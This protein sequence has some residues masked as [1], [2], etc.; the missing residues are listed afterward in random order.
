MQSALPMTL[1]E[2]IAALRLLYD[3]YGQN[4][5][6]EACSKQSHMEQCAT[7]A[8]EQGE[9][10]ELQL[11]AFLHDVGHLLAEHRQIEERDALGFYNHSELGAEYL[12]ELGFASEIV[13]LV[14]FHVQAKRY[15]ATVD[16]EY[17]EHLSAASL[18]T[19]KQQGGPMNG[20]ESAAF[21]Q[22]ANLDE[23]LRLRRL[24]DLGKAAEADT[25]NLDHW[26]ELGR[27][28]LESREPVAAAV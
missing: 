24:D 6:T 1:D 5:Y 27:R 13:S 19:L 9:S 22:Y 25:R 20:P 11:A 28:H 3:G 2:K 10:E 12:E 17:L 16:A 7:A 8:L 26:L 15:L 23:L 21:A 4:A 14:R 18:A